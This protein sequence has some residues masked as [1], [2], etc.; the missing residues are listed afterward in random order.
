MN[1]G[2]DIALDPLLTDDDDS[3]QTPPATDKSLRQQIADKARQGQTRL[4]Q[5]RKRSSEDENS[6]IDQAGVEQWNKN[7][8]ALHRAAKWD[9]FM[10][11]SWEGHAALIREIFGEISADSEGFKSHRKDCQNAVKNGKTLTI[12]ATEVSSSHTKHFLQTSCSIQSTSV[13]V[14]PK[15]QH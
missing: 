11:A 4:R 8:R 2:H 1:S 5:S 6:E 3:L 13:Y 12:A 15:K 14:Y 10:Y 7:V 9:A